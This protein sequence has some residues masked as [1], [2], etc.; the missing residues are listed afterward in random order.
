[1]QQA[2]EQSTAYLTVTF[3]NKAGAAEAPVTA[4]YRIHDVGSGT[5]VRAWTA[6]TD[7]AGS[8]ELTFSPED[9]T[10]LVADNPVEQRRVTVVGTY[11]DHDAVTSEFIYE[12]VNLRGIT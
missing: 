11:G 2:N 3:R 4:K 9:N 10:L 6:I 8:V 12:V 1:M 5:E 7:P